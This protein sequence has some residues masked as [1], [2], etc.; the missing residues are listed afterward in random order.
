MENLQP[1]EV[2][3]RSVELF[4]KKSIRRFAA[5]VAILGVMLG[6]VADR[7]VDRT[8]D[9]GKDVV[10][11]VLQE[12]GELL[13]SEVDG[14]MNNVENDAKEAKEK[15]NNIEENVEALKNW[16]EENMGVNFEPEAEKN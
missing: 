12:Q 6:V 2:P 4:P 10:Q 11:P 13:R 7:A 8:I 14:S 16:F 15:V 9:Q 3:K 1:H 5:K